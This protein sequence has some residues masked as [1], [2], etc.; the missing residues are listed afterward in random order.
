MKGPLRRQASLVFAEM[1]DTGAGEERRAQENPQVQG[2]GARGVPWRR[3]LR[4]RPLACFLHAWRRFWQD[5]CID[6]AALLAYTTLLAII[7][8]AAV[9]LWLWNRVG[10][11]SLDRAQLARYIFENF[12]PQTANAILVNINTLAARGAQ[13]GIFGV[14]GLAA[15]AI[16][17]LYAVERHLNAIWRVHPRCWWCRFLRYAGILVLGPTALAFVASLLLPLQPLLAVIMPIPTLPP[18]ATVALAFLVE[19][20]VL[21]AVYQWL[22]ATRVR[23]RDAMAGG[24]SAAALF[25]LS[26]IGFAWY[27]EFS[28]FQALYGAL[29]VFPVFLLWIYV[30][31]A[32]VLY[33]GEMAA[34]CGEKRRAA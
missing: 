14:L 10:F 23:W 6:R 8:L 31:W 13:L 9:V 28:T 1:R 22:P 5:D 19:T 29:G 4:V 17:L 20:L 27:L 34:A 11:G 30:A 2:G 33:G 24:L 16:L 25:E 7:P 3:F 12:L 15:S 18:V 32:S 21:T 26:K